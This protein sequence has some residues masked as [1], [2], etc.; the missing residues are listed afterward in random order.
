MSFIKTKSP[1]VI[2]SKF[3]HDPLLEVNITWHCAVRE[4][5]AKWVVYKTCKKWYTKWRFTAGSIEKTGWDQKDQSVCVQQWHLT[6]AESS[7]STARTLVVAT[8]PLSNPY[9][10]PA[11]L[12]CEVDQKSN[13]RMLCAWETGI[14]QSFCL[15]VSW[16]VSNLLTMKTCWDNLIGIQS[17]SKSRH[18]LSKSH[19][20]L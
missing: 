3:I 8:G 19:K 11:V 16:R 20:H 17:F 15:D 12:P 10:H 9:L 13:W 7:L 4:R 18:W 14:T 1:K 5:A 6:G 2:I